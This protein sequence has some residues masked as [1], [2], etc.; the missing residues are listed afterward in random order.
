MFLA[1]H[2][3]KALLVSIILY[4]INCTTSAQ[5]VCLQQVI[6]YYYDAHHH[7]LIV[8]LCITGI[9]IPAWS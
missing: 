5:A 2:F 8:Q 9:H 4:R 6:Y 7:I 1:A 3:V